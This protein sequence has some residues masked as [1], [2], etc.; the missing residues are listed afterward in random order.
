MVHNEGE[1]NETAN[2]DDDGPWS[3]VSVG[4]IIFVVDLIGRQRGNRNN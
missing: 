3:R 1:Q 2:E 4:I